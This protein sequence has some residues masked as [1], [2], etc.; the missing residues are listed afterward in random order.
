MNPSA[1]CRLM[2]LDKPAGTVLLWLPTASA[3]W[4]AN[5]EGVPVSLLILFFAGTCL[6]RAAG[7]VVNDIADRH[8]DRFVARTDKRPLASGEVGLLPALLLLSVLLFAALGVLLQLPAA[9]F[10]W[11][12]AALA[13]TWLYP[14]C[15]RFFHAPQLVLGLAFSMGIPMAF[16]ASGAPFNRFFWL[17][18]FANTLWVIAYD[19]LYAMADVKDDVRAGMRSTALL[20]GKYDRLITG[21]L[22]IVTQALWLFMGV[23]LQAGAGYWLA[24]LAAFLPLVSQLYL[25]KGRRPEDCTRAFRISVWYGSLLWLA[26]I[27]QMQ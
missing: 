21:L 19:T 22:L 1:L 7:C 26:L 6:M 11:A 14:F 20:F 23:F 17:L 16:V 18:L 8:L 10:P 15:K 12:L 24:W 25:T 13:I 9:C 5:P 27:L 2:R 3:F 4:L